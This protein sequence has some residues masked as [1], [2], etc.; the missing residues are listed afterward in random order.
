MAELVGGDREQVVCLVDVEGLRRCRSRC[1]R[2]ARSRTG[3]AGAPGQGRVAV[4]V[5]ADADVARAG[6]TLLVVPAARGGPVVWDDLEVDVG[7]RGPGLA[8]RRICCSTGGGA[9]LMLG[10]GRGRLALLLK[11]ALQLLVIGCPGCSSRRGGSGM[12]LMVMSWGFI[13]ALPWPSRARRGTPATRVRAGPSA[14]GTPGRASE[15]RLS[16]HP[17]ERSRYFPEVDVMRTGTRPASRSAYADA[18]LRPGAD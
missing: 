1:R 3:G 18:P 11:V 6:V 15:R 2:P 12:K 5:A 10:W 9:E 14:I 4:V 7:R 13:Q 17:E 16:N 8:A